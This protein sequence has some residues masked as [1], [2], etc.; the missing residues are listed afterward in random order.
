MVLYS[1]IVSVSSKGDDTWLLELPFLLLESVLTPFVEKMTIELKG[2]HS[3]LDGQYVGLEIC[4]I[5]FEI[6]FWFVMW[7]L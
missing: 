2:L 5:I 3:F 1:H 7:Q 4:I 6:P